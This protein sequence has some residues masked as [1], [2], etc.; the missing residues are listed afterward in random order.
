MEYTFKLFIT[1]DFGSHDIRT[2]STMAENIDNAYE[3][4]MNQFYDGRTDGEYVYK[5]MEM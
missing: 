1:D 3:K 2:Y 4:I 5:V